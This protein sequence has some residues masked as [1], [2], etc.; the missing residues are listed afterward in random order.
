MDYH[1]VVNVSWNDATAYR[2]WLSKTHDGVKYELPTEAHWEFACR[3]GTTTTG[4]YGDSEE[5]M[6]QHGWC[7]KN[8]RGKTHPVGQLRSNGFGVYDM[9]GNAWEWCQDYYARNHDEDRL[10]KTSVDP[11][12]PAG[13]S[14]RVLRGVGWFHRAGH[15]R[16][17]MR[18]SDSPD[19]SDSNTGFR[20]T[21]VVAE[22]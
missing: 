21:A 1:P 13:G 4:H 10:G 20:L 22:K 3:A 19:H 9:H 17:A 2:Q 15:C 11:L 6:R 7:R 16:S 12:G 5:E 8:A 18:N 14:R